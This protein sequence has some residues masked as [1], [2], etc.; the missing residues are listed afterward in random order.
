MRH[1]VYIYCTQSNLSG[2]LQPTLSFTYSIKFCSRICSIQCSPHEKLCLFLQQEKYRVSETFPRREKRISVLCK[3]HDV[4]KAYRNFSNNN[5]KNSIALL[6]VVH[7]LSQQKRKKE[8]RIVLNLLSR[9]KFLTG[10]LT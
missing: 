10:Y 7:R 3:F 1:N 4:R 8:I 9:S 2:Y 6:H 5:R